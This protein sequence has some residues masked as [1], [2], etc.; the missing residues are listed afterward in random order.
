MSLL[1]KKIIAVGCSHVY[2]N[3]AGDY[4]NITADGVKNCHERSWAN[5][6]LRFY[7]N[8]ECVNLA[9]P[10]GSNKRS[11]RVIK[12]YVLDNLDNIK[13]SIIFFGVTD[14][15]RTEF[16]SYGTF[17]STDVYVEDK[18]YNINKLGT[19]IEADNQPLK[20]FLKLYYGVFYVDEHAKLELNLDLITLH[21]FLKNLKIE[22]YFVGILITEKDIDEY[23]KKL[24]LP[25]IIWTK[26]AIDH[27]RDYGFKVGNDV[28]GDIGCNHLDHDGNDF[29][30][31]QIYKKI[32]E[33]KNAK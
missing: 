10:G 6:I 17:G 30:A 9:T 4:G 15:A 33:I 31:K 21:M 27:V 29:L 11:F 24:K 14:I 13:D 25:I 8:Y 1:T 28:Y 2:G 16:P 5:K 23:C 22:H 18:K 26:N 7:K 20:Q 32:I 19:W 12:Q 3:Y